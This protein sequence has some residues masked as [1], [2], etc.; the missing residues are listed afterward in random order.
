MLNVWQPR[1]RIPKGRIL[2]TSILDEVIIEKHI[3]LEIN[4]DCEKI[5]FGIGFSY[6]VVANGDNSKTCVFQSQAIGSLDC[7][8]WLSTSEYSNLSEIKLLIPESIFSVW[9]SECRVGIHC[10]SNPTEWSIVENIF[11]NELVLS[12]RNNESLRK[13]PQIVELHGSI[14]LKYFIFR[15]WMFFNL[16]V[17]RLTLAERVRASEEKA[18]S[19]RLVKT[20]PFNY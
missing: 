1:K 4:R 13:S 8:N 14:G 18:Q 17:R 2:I 16:D 10:N 19:F 12:D 9:S 11:F 15:Y 7:Y 6:S 20:K 5:K 3:S